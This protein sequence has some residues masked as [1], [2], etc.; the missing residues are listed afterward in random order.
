[1]RS[2][3]FQLPSFLPPS[4]TQAA[5]VRWL[6]RKA[7]THVVRD[8]K[9]TD[10]VVAVSSYKSLIHTAVTKSGGVDWYTG[11]MLS[12]DKI[13]SYD[14]H[15]SKRGRTVYK[16]GF[17]LLP[18]VDHV[19]TDAG[20]DFVICGWATNDAKGD[21]S[22]PEFLEKCRRVLAWHARDLVGMDVDA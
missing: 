4:V 3:K 6:E 22:L 13:S 21:L 7:K 11:E 8:R 17:A 20:W 9:R 15:E 16:A 19:A 5:Y 10:R 1:V 12:W 2:P 14:N 18:T